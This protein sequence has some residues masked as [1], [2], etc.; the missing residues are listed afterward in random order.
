MK[1]ILLLLLA[2]AAFSAVGCS[3]E[4]P[5]EPNLKTVEIPKVE[6]S[7]HSTDLTCYS[8]GTLIYKGS[9]I[10]KIGMMVTGTYQIKDKADGKEKFVS[11]DCVA[12]VQK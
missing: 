7:D 2:C 9:S 11:G 3:I 8:G 10:G 5:A 12:I 1:T 6:V 4:P